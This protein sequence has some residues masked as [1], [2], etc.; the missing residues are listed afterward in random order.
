MV[1]HTDPS[2]EKSDPLIFGDGVT[3]TPNQAFEDAN[4]AG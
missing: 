1:V 4:A 3:L 2:A